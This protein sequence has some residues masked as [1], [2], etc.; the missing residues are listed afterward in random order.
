MERPDYH[1]IKA[2]LNKAKIA[3]ENSLSKANGFDFLQMK[4]II[5]EIDEAKAFPFEDKGKEEPKPREILE[6]FAV[7]AS[8][9]K[10][11]QDI[12]REIRVF[13]FVV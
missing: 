13:S 7:E 10:V 4:E 8:E 5:N 12:F 2:G 3:I 11:N 1:E 9:S 6:S